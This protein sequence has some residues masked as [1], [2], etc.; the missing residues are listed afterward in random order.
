MPSDREGAVDVFVS[1]AHEDEDLCDEL[2]KHLTILEREGEIR[3]WHDRAILPGEAWGSAIDHRLNAADVIL[4][5]VSPDFMASKYCFDVEL[6]RA[7]ERQK[8][9]SAR[10]VPIILRPADWSRAPFSELQLLPKDGR[11]VT[12]WSDRDEAFLNVQQGL[13]AVIWSEQ[14]RRREQLRGARARPSPERPKASSGEAK[15]SASKDAVAPS[16]WRRRSWAWGL[17]GLAAIVL[18]IAAFGGLSG[19]AEPGHGF[20]A[21]RESYA[22]VHRA[23]RD[24]IGG[25][26][27]RMNGN[28]SVFEVRDKS[29]KRIGRWRRGT[30]V[31]VV[32]SVVGKAEGGRWLECRK[33]E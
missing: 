8:A 32:R 10:V 33:I 29:S 21:I 9:G 14:R 31:R 2:R 27:L 11:P 12:S 4:L 5:L 25:D 22:N 1:Y 26:E 15:V 18:L 13:R 3:S 23:G 30:R 24:P 17:G 28:V 6:P 19:G 7:L 16:P 20:I